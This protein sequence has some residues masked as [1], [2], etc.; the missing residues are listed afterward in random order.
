VAKSW[1]PGHLLVQSSDD[2]QAWVTAGTFA[3]FAPAAVG[4][5]PGTKRWWVNYDIVPSGAHRFW[6]VAAAD[7]APD[8][9][10]G[11]DELVFHATQNPLT[12][13]G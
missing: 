9:F 1:L 13:V 12:P 10:F 3:P 4:D 6:R 5:A 7:M 2:G 11:L 8:H